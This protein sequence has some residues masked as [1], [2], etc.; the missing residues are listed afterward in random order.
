MDNH[1]HETSMSGGR[2]VRF[3]KQGA[4]CATVLAVLGGCAATSG[5]P[6]KEIVAE[7]AQQRWDL[8]VK[9]DFAG[10]YRYIS[11]AGRQIVTEQAYISGFQKR[12]FWTSAKVTEVECPTAEA[13]D[14][15]LQIE[16]QHLGI[17]MKNGVREKWVR[18]KSEWWF[19]L[20]R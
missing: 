2:A 7:R 10:A 18:D 1:S 17:R 14:V 20:E 15:E 19:L 16:Y 13:C 12:N 11:P 8:L 5:K 6:A 3:M 4:A 9:N